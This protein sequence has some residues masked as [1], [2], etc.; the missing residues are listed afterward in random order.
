MPS[1]FISKSIRS[2]RYEVFKSSSADE[3]TK[4]KMIHSTIRLS[5]FYE[6]S[7]LHFTSETVA[8]IIACDYLTI[9]TILST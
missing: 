9:Q 8:I 1:F 6:F 2:S 4:V 7:I 5:S 3:L